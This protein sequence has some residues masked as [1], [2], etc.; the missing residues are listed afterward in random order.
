MRVTP[1]LYR[2]F[3]DTIISSASRPPVF[4]RPV[5]HDPFRWLRLQVVSKG[6]LMSTKSKRPFDAQVFLASAG[7]SRKIIEYPRGTSI[8]TQ[9]DPCDHVLYI[10]KGNVKLSV[11]STIRP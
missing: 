1:A 11:L 10:Q 9:G 4:R 2:A 3:A 6:S 5:A 7:V 8:F